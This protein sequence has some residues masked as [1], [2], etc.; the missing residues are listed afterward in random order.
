MISVPM[1]RSWLY[2][3]YLMPDTYR[4]PSV[5]PARYRVVLPAPMSMESLTLLTCTFYMGVLSSLLDRNH[6]FQIVLKAMLSE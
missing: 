3:N 2:L 1:Y 5:F 4:L 6:H